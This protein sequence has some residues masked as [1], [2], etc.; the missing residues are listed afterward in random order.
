MD[1]FERIAKDSGG[2]LGQYRDKAFGYYQLTRI[3][4]DELLYRLR[5]DGFPYSVFGDYSGYVEYAESRGDGDADVGEQL[6]EGTADEDQAKVEDEAAVE[7]AAQDETAD[8]PDD[9]E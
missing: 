1:I 6:A 4:T 9:K 3:T 7:E 8:S 5:S 2:P